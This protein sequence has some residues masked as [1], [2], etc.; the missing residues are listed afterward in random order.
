MHSHCWQ[1]KIP[2]YRWILFKPRD[3]QQHCKDLSK[4]LRNI[5]TVDLFC[6]EQ[7]FVVLRLDPWTTSLAVLLPTFADFSSVIPDTQL[8]HSIIPSD[9]IFLLFFLYLTAD[10]SSMLVPH[11]FLTCWNCS[12]YIL[13][14]LF[15]L[16]CVPD[17]ITSGS[18]VYVFVLG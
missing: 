18:D 16:D 9:W 7:V 13:S 15:P 14:C 3:Q 6:I 4:L 8:L 2:M 11:T 1:C 10:L 17:C 5:Y 12:F